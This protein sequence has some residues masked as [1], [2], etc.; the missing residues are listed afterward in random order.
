MRKLLEKISWKTRR[1]NY[2]FT[3]LNLHLHDHEGTWGFNLCTFYINFRT[4]SLLSIEVRLPNLTHVRKFVVDDWDFLYLSRPLYTKYDKLT[5]RA[6]YGSKLS[7]G[8]QIFIKLC[9]KV[10]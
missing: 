6:L 5:D 8:E 2:K 1:W 4:Y 10:F 9:N 3:L 7:K